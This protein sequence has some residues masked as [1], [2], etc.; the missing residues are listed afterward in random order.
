MKHLSV[1]SIPLLSLALGCG[2]DTVS[3]TAEGE[4]PTSTSDPEDSTGAPGES[5]AA[6]PS[7][8]S[9]TGA[10]DTGSATTIDPDS[11]TGTASCDIYLQD[12]PEGEKCTIWAND[13]GNIPNANRCVPIADDPG[14][15]GDPCVVEGSPY[16]GLDD[17]ELG[18]W[19][20]DPDPKTLEGECIA[21]CLG[22]E[23]NPTCDPGFACVINARV[24]PLCFRSCDPLAPECDPGEGC[25]PRD[26]HWLCGPV[27][28]EAGYGEECQF[29][30]ACSAGLFCLAPEL[31][32]GCEEGAT[33]CCTEPCA[34]DDP[35]C[36]AA[37]LGAVCEPWYD[38]PA[39]EGYENLG[40]C[41]LPPP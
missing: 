11:D 21:F 16:S 37:D 36:Q 41:V 7:V 31:V 2:P 8:D 19:C 18:S 23:R 9:S 39:P 40:A 20:L 29:S 34:L 6:N 13:G 24:P 30:N 38:A 28:I 14:A 1:I 26:E 12:C 22:D 4:S 32:A 25:Y 35:I 33:G 5:T 17:C 10:A 27:G 3:T 15:P